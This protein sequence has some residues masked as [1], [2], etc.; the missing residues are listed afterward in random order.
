MQHRQNRR[1]IEQHYATCD[2]H[3]ILG[4]DTSL[5]DVHTFLMDKLATSCPQH[6]GN[7]PHTEELE[8]AHL[9]LILALLTALCVCLGINQV[10]AYEQSTWRNW[11]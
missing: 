5:I 9:P 7:E 10:P 3:S 8:A 1:K 2:H 6:G 11:S 4:P